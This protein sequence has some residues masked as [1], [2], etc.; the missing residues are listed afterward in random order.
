M[1]FK[2]GAF[3]F[4]KERGFIKQLTH[5]KETKEML[6]ARPVTFYFGID[7]TADNLHIGHFFGLRVFKILQDFGHKGILLIGNATA[8]I[9][10]PSFKN[11]MRKMMTAEE[12][13]EN[14]KGIEKVV[15]KFI[16]MDT[17]TIVYNADWTN[18]RTYLD[19]MREVGSHFNVNRM[20]SFENYK[21]RLTEGGL[22]FFEMGYMLMQAY[23]FIHLNNEFGCTLQLCGSDQWANVVAGVELGRKMS[24]KNGKERPQ[25]VGLSTPLLTNKDGTK[26]GKTEKGTLWVH[27]ENA[28]PFDFYQY[29]INVDDAEVEQLLK[30]FGDM[31]VQEIAP[32]I[33]K[34]I[35]EAKKKL[36]YDVTKLVHGKEAADEVVET[37]RKMFYKKEV[38]DILNDPS[39]PMAAFLYTDLVIAFD[40]K[41]VKEDKVLK[42][43]MKVVDFL[44]VLHEIFFSKREIRDLIE[45]GGIT[46]D[47][48][49]IESTDET[50]DLIYRK[51]YLVKKGKK[52]FLKVIVK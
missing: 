13:K 33:T 27:G 42:A 25:L 39:V 8:A 35:R 6:D 11:E 43:E 21:N 45:N 7:P 31:T 26:M 3:K 49:K 17:A 22:T 30:F 36:A 24:L 4:L 52:T 44:S 48:K 2:Q 41:T 50:I 34:D 16:N 29:F 23:D 46:I 51:D 28:K 20:L 9:G 47:A 32:L 40:L 15:K 18:N 38:T 37:T 19:F 10:D 12:L 14:S 1:E 5:E